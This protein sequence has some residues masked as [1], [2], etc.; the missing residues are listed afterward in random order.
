MDNPLHNLTGEQK[1]QLLITVD[2]NGNPTGIATRAHCHEGD[3]ITHM[4][5]MA[6]VVDGNNNIVLTKR[7]DTKSLFAKMWDASVVSHVLP[8]ETIEEA[9]KRR[10]REELGI[11][12]HFFN[13]GAFYYFA[14]HGSSAEN[15]YC[16]VL[17]GKSDEGIFINPVEI[18]EFKKVTLEKLLE[19]GKS[20]PDL[21]APWLLLS[22]EKIDLAKHIK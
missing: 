2:T 17:I 22:L 20:N 9:A 12:T 15:E 13:V 21:F 1:D 18:S 3:G 11:D 16:H 8:A 10:G 7:S 19:E 6:F 14:K 5:F 4:A